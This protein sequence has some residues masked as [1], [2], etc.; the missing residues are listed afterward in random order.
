VALTFAPFGLRAVA[1][2]GSH[3]GE[4]RP[5][6]LPNGATCPDLQKGA[7]VKMTLGVVTS[8]GTGAGP[9]LGVA[10]GFAWIDSTSGL[11]L[12]SSIPADTS[13]AGTF[14]G[15][16]RPVVYVIDNPNT[17]FMVQADASVTVADL[18]LNFNVTASGTD[19]VNSY[20]ISRYCL[21]A[22]SRTSALTGA[23]KIVGLA[24]VP[25]NAWGDPFPWVLVRM[26]SIVALVSAA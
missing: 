18:G 9:I 22:D 20:G 16:N 13:S 14:E 11:L 23:L 21:D 24:K 19:L 6:P 2:W 17:I 15:E 26:N 25:D 12:K 10:N 7:P 4:Q 8:C 1:A 3:G 5:Y